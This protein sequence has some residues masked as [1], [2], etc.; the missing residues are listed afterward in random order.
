MIEGIFLLKK[1]H[2]QSVESINVEYSLLMLGYQEKNRIY[3]GKIRFIWKK[4]S[5]SVKNTILS[6]KTN[7]IRK[8]SN[9]SNIIMLKN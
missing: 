7:A 1:S 5:I 9:F 8:N 6:G 4:R 3:Q 2:I